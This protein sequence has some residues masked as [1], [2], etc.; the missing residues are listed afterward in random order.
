MNNSNSLRPL[1][2][3]P[4]NTT[5]KGFEAVPYERSTS[6]STTVEDSPSES[7]VSYITTIGKETLERLEQ[8]IQEPISVCTQE[9]EREEK[10]EQL[11]EIARKVEENKRILQKTLQMANNEVKRLTQE[12]DKLRK[13]LYS[14]PRVEEHQVRP[15]S[16]AVLYQMN[17]ICSIRVVIVVTLVIC[18]CLV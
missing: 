14:R 6:G 13:E 8:L 12:A 5:L 7:F 2:I 11:M 17:L 15:S 18:V 9:E 3:S 16:S 4:E 1:P 10:A